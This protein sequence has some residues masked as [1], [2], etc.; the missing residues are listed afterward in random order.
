MAW[1]NMKKPTA[2]A[3]APDMQE[4]ASDLSPAIVLV[5]GGGFFDVGK[6]TGL[7]SIVNAVHTKRYFRPFPK[8]GGKA[9]PWGA[10]HVEYS[11]DGKTQL[12][13]VKQK[14]CKTRA[15]AES[16]TKQWGDEL[17]AKEAKYRAML[18]AAGREPSS[19]EQDLQKAR[20]KILRQEYPDTFKAMD[21]P[22]TGKAKRNAIYRAYLVDLVR[23]FKSVNLDDILRDKV[24]PLDWETVSKLAVA[25]AAPIPQ[26]RLDRAIAALWIHGGYNKMTRADYTRRLNAIAGTNLTPDAMRMR[27]ERLGLTSA[28]ERPGPAPRS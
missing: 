11:Q 12:R 19:G 15:E 24:T 17:R 7:R 8:E 26:R 14:L 22:P 28:K 4:P 20:L 1:V 2:P 23:L 13:I 21:A 3:N 27:V 9:W 25:H 6:V 16:Q 18:K 5:Q 10:E